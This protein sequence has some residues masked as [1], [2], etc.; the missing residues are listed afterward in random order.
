SA[1][2]ISAAIHSRGHA[3]ILVATGNSQFALVKHLVNAQLDWSRV[4]AFH[5]DEY[6]G[7]DANHPA[8]FRHW[9]RTRF[10]EKVL[11][12]SMHYLRGDAPDPDAEAARYSALLLAGPIDL[13]FVGIGE[14]GHIAFND[15]HVADFNDPLT[16][17]RVEL[18]V[19]CRTQQVHEGHFPNI[20]AV[21]REALSVTCS[22][23]MRAAHW[24]CSVPEARKAEAVRKSLEGPITPA[25]PGSL[26]RAHPSAFLYLDLES[27]SKLTH[28]LPRSHP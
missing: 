3:R 5:L 13:A 2:I 1:E 8:S 10:E 21:P 4:D 20:A 15:P 17:K 9:I 6:V 24:V 23:L 26:V 16:V 18:D 14:N 22:G 19:A 27:S 11:P 7:I 12:R 28:R 25:C